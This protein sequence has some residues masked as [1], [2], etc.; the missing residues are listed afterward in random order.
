MDIILEPVTKTLTVLAGKTATF[1]C[2][3]TGADLK[4]YQMSWYKKNEDNSLT[5]VYRQSNRS[6]DNLRSNFKGKADVLKSQYIL[7]ILKAATKDAGTYYCGC[8]IHSAAVLLL[9][10]SEPQGGRLN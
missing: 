7:D 4:N 9:P 3:I 8:D 10:A 6:S 1:Y 5:L 2:S